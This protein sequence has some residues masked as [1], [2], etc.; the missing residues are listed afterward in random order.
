MAPTLHI[1][2]PEVNKIIQECKAAMALKSNLAIY[3][4]IFTLNTLDHEVPT[5]SLESFR[6]LQGESGQIILSKGNDKDLVKGMLSLS[7]A[8]LTNN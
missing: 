1:S 3:L 6:E 7:Q 2:N 4:P 5:Q 8:N